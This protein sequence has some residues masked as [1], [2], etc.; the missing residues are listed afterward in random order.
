MHTTPL[1]QKFRYKTPVYQN[2]KNLMKP[3]FN[4]CHVDLFQCSLSTNNKKHTP[5]TKGWFHVQDFLEANAEMR[6]NKIWISWPIVSCI[7][8]IKIAMRF[9][10]VRQPSSEKTCECSLVL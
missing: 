5:D 7:K 9:L 8:I 2:L 4:H 1:Y 6:D 3:Q 10:E